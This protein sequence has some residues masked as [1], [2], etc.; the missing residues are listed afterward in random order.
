METGCGFGVTLAE[1]V[2]YSDLRCCDE[3][4]TYPWAGLLLD[5]VSGKSEFVIAAV[6]IAK[7]A[8]IL[9]FCSWCRV[10]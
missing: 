6:M 7:V 4:P 5:I 9:T 3:G 10:G 2:D 1:C 8:W